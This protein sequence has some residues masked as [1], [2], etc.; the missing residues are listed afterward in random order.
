[1]RIRIG[2]RDPR[3]RNIGGRNMHGIER[4]FHLFVSLQI[5]FGSRRGLSMLLPLLLVAALVVGGWFFFTSVNSP[6]SKLEQAHADWGFRRIDTTDL[7][8][9]A[10]SKTFTDG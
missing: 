8:D 2:G 6:Q 3:F 7:G 5:L 10:V 1:M 4:M 9:Q